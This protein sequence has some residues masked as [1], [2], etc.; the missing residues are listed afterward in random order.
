MRIK[1]GFMK[2]GNKFT[3]V[4]LILCIAILVTTLYACNKNPDAQTPSDDGNTDV[5]TD[6]IVQQ[7][8]TCTDTGLKYRI[9]K[10][11]VK[12]EETIPALGHSYGEWQQTIAPTTTSEGSEQRK[13]TRC[14]DVEE[15]KISA[16]V[17]GTNGLE[18]TYWSSNDMYYITGVGKA[19]NESKLVIPSK[20]MGK[21]VIYVYKNS[22]NDMPNLET[23]EFSKDSKVTTIYEN[24]FTNCPKLKT[25][26][27]PASVTYVS[28]SFAPNCP[29]FESITVDSEN[30]K[31]CSVD[32]IMYDTDKSIIYV[33]PTAKA[34]KFVV[35]NTVK[36][37]QD[38]TNFALAQGFGITEFGVESEDSN[39]IVDDGVLYT[40]G[41]NVYLQAY[42][43][44][45]KGSTFTTRN[46]LRGISSY[47]L[48]NNN[49]LKNLI[50][51]N[52][53]KGLIIEKYSI[54]NTSIENITFECNV[55]S[56]GD[57]SINNNTK[58]TEVVFNNVD[59]TTKCTL[60]AYSFMDCT[61]LKRITLPS[62]LSF[63]EPTTNGMYD[64]FL[65]CK[66]LEYIDI[67]VD[68][69]TQYTSVDGVLYDKTGETLW[70]IPG[71]K[72]DLKFEKTLKNIYTLSMKYSTDDYLNL[73]YD[74]DEN[75]LKYY[76]NWL[77]NADV[78]KSDVV[79]RDGTV[80]I[81]PVAFGRQKKYNSVTLPSS[82]KY[83]SPDVFSQTTVTEFIYSN[84]FDYIAS[85][86]FSEFY[87]TGAIDLGTPSYIG[88]WAF[89][90][91]K[92]SEVTVGFKDNGNN[93]VIAE[94]AF[95]SS[96]IK[97]LYLG[98][99]VESVGTSAYSK[100]KTLSELYIANSELC[101]TMISSNVCWDNYLE[102][103]WF[104]NSITLSEKAIDRLKGIS[105]K[106]AKTDLTCTINGVSYYCYGK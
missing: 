45:K 88:A 99:Y 59:N 75:G 87:Y 95:Y 28:Q 71:A 76:E 57:N 35:P 62:N 40:K 4:M 21:T 34:G 94:K 19:I 102:K 26:S 54:Y 25:V 105:F 50:V 61:A 48:Y 68:E 97:K 30:T 27:I 101:E 80:G 98:Q 43:H 104:A 106:M 11:G 91:A 33:Y 69:N 72:K 63:L 86:A 14:G 29:S 82:V 67:Q 20:Y 18:Y 31:Y 53:E 32:G 58:L 17:D 84:N 44:S 81:A 92:V 73:K 3:M 38:I 15:Q 79:V 64:P 6:W 93:T 46:D 66:N 23:V 16:L 1:G 77:I 2:K 8:P 89:S 85:N 103:V 22:L 5:G 55:T 100:V 47:S 56:I 12:Q 52:S 83:L 96:L 42:P 41:N 39:F 36:A 7:E 13:C 78:G 24:A 49:S 70:L 37:S 74:Y 10:N 65:R 90:A 9:D 60:G 51:A